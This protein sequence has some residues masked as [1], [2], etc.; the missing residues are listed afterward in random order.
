MHKRSLMLLLS[1]IALLIM[2]MLAFALLYRN[3]VL[4]LT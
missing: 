1:I 3:D 4:Q 2:G